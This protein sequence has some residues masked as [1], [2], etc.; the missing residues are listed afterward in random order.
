VTPP[1]PV[2][3]T[4]ALVR[5]PSVTPEEAGV[6]AL[7]VAALEPLG[8]TCRRLVFGPA[9]GS[10]AVPNLFAR[11]GERP[12]VLL[13]NGHTDVVPP[14]ERGSWS[15]DPFAGE[16]RDGR[17]F[18]RGAA[19]MKSAI[20]A[21]VAAVGRVLAERGGIPG[22]IVLLLTNDEEGPAVCGSR[23]LVEWFL[24]SG[25]RFDAAIVGE[26]TSEERVGDT[27]KIGRRGSLTGQLT[28][29]GRQ[30]HVAYPE[31]A[32]NAAHG[33]VR[34]LA[35]LIDAPLDGGSEHFAPST[36]QVTT[37]DVG[38]PATNVVP[39]HARAT[40]NVRFNDRHDVASLERLLRDRLDAARA[41]YELATTCSAEPFLTPPGPL[42]RLVGDAVERVQGFRPR[43]S[44]SGGTSD[45]RFLVA[46][47]PVVELG[48]VGPSMHQSDEHVAVADVGTLTDVYRTVI[49]LFFERW[50]C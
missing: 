41:P 3:L 39:A 6:F 45:A 32:E 23:A 37:I 18:G 47:G 7:L 13:F 22:S 27:V 29:L 2:E 40:F 46:H 50:R 26:P 33:M 36:L 4:R 28:A 31:R 19:D 48:I 17:L 14:G 34:L 38:N 16:I 44:T 5:C 49:R 15:V 43:L 35:R 8:F 12:P 21:F 9:Q 20:A 10:P 30:G 1:D 11:L 24:A 42:T 25:G